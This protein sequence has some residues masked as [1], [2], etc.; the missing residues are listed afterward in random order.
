MTY[1]GF[2]FYNVNACEKYPIEHQCD[3]L[4]MHS[5][6]VEDR[7]NYPNVMFFDAENL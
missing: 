4:L 1:F 2:L 7:A 3:T 5:K 6:C